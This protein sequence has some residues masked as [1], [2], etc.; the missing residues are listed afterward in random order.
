M[1]HIINLS[2]A[3]LALVAAPVFTACSDDETYDFDGSPNN[4]V[5][6][7]QQG[8]NTVEATLYHTPAGEFGALTLEVPAKLQYIGDASVSV[9]AELA[10]DLVAKY[11][12]DNETEYAPLPASVAS[13]LVVTPG[14]IQPGSQ[15]SETPV[16]V[17]IPESV[18]PQ[19]TE[20]AYV[21]PVRMKASVSGNGGSRP[22]AASEHDEMITRYLVIHTQQADKFAEFTGSSTAS[23][24][25]VKTPVGTFGGIDAQ[26]SCR[27]PIAIDSDI[28]ITAEA[29]NALV[30]QWNTDN[31][32]QAAT[33]PASALAALKMEGAIATGETSG[34]VRITAPV[35]KLAELTEPLYVLPLHLGVE[36]ANGT[37]QDMGQVCYVVIE[38]KESL[39]QDDPQAMLG[40]AATNQSEW[41]CVSSEGLDGA[42]NPDG[43]APAKQKQDVAT[44]MVDLGGTHKF[45]G[46]SYK[47]YVAE[48]F[49]V[50]LSEDG[51]NWTDLGDTSGKGTCYDS[52]YNEWYV[53]YGAV[54]A[55]YVKCQVNYNASSYYWNYWNYSWGKSYCSLKFNFAYND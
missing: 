36:Y 42:M 29:D 6:V 2:L 52:Y 53:L 48:N 49:H 8:G 47:C 20:P 41:T 27:I 40:S 26:F 25:I 5:F 51:Q 21:M 46:F 7:N 44:F 4:L 54:K 43:W 33:L 30:S 39:L 15:T 3:A 31:G 38:Q 19:L 9:T 17:S 28:K 10:P 12:E 34:S 22:I 16:T 24:A 50:W 45:S 1:K 55:R 14:T 11:N 18:R 37:R 13:E 35:E 32:K 23:C